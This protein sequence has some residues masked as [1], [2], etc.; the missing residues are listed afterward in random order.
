MSFLNAAKRG[1]YAE[2]FREEVQTEPVT[3]NTK[4]V[5][6]YLHVLNRGSDETLR[7]NKSYLQVALKAVP[8][9]GCRRW[10]D[11][12][13]LRVIVHPDAVKLRQK[14]RLAEMEKE[15]PSPRRSGAPFLLTCNTDLW[16][17]AILVDSQGVALSPKQQHKIKLRD[18]ISKRSHSPPLS[19][20]KMTAEQTQL[21]NAMFALPQAAMVLTE[22]IAA[23]TQHHRA[24]ERKQISNQPRMIQKRAEVRWQ[25]SRQ[26]RALV[27]F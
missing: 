13:E 1:A 22:A 11:G 17:N 25:T 20:H 18:A 9:R 8:K 23:T 26:S 14:R 6:S 2:S 3:G 5:F 15:P 21:L 12:K 10:S 27:A 19:P 4:P 7:T 24:V 16:E